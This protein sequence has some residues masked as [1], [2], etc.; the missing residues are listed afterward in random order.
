L[1]VTGMFILGREAMRPN[2]RSKKFKKR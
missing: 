1:G 2:F